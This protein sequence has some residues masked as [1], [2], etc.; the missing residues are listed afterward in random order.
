ML[1]HLLSKI[2]RHFCH[3]ENL[4]LVSASLMLALPMISN[5][6]DALFK[7]VLGQPEHARGM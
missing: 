6:H 3:P 7:V 4:P 2:S 1:K 5:P